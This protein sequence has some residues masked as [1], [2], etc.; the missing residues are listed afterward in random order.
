MFEGQHE[1]TGVDSA[2]SVSGELFPLVL[3]EMVTPSQGL[4]YLYSRY[5]N[6]LKEDSGDAEHGSMLDR[7]STQQSK[8]NDGDQDS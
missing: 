8:R 1:L 7:M 3:S 5:G 4:V 6:D 2:I